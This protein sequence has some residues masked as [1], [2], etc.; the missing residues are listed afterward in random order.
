[1][2]VPVVSTSLGCEGLDVVDG[3]SVLLADSDRAMADA[4]VRV[5]QVPALTASLRAHGATVAKSYDWRR[6]GTLLDAVIRTAAALPGPCRA[7]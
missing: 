1:M 3:R 7:H 4:L 6:I 2:G 5:L